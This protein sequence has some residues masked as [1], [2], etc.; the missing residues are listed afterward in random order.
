MQRIVTDAQRRCAPASARRE[1][2]ARGKSPSS[3][4]CLRV[5]LPRDCAALLVGGPPRAIT[6]LVLIGFGP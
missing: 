6:I 5:A 1:A 2:V 3:V 4:A